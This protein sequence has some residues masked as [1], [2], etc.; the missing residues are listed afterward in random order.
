[1]IRRPPRS[2]L[3]PYTTLFRSL[4]ISPGDKTSHPSG[5]AM[6]TISGV[7]RFFHYIEGLGDT[8]SEETP[9]PDKP[10]TTTTTTATHRLRSNTIHPKSDHHQPHHSHKTTTQQTNPTKSQQFISELNAGEHLKLG[11]TSTQVTVSRAAINSG[12]ITE[13]SG[14]ERNSKFHRPSSRNT[15]HH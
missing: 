5:T 13:A 4:S 2:T 11:G 6:V 3:F 14:A 1:M 12:E 7:F 15:R 10:R 8:P 9:Q